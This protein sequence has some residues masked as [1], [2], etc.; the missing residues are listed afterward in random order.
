[1]CP[2]TL[3]LS[4]YYDGELSDVSRK[5]I[6]KHLEGCPTC[7]ATLEIFAAQ[8]RYLQSETLTPPSDH[9]RLDRFWHY[10]GKFRF[11]RYHGVP[12]RIGVPLPL[13]VAVIL[14]L[15]VATGFN[16]VIREGDSRPGII[17]LAPRSTAP[18]LV[19]FS[20]TPSDLE[21]F[22]SILEG[23]TSGNDITYTLPEGI[24]VSHFGDPMIIRSTAP[25]RS[26]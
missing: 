6:G 18:T 21:S 11:G 1:M 8:H 13:A 24:P 23:E 17:V 10:V 22:L 14:A 19:T 5:S 9:E 16:F 12:R 26:P 7:R 2:E 20:I 25:E 4:A 15:I 3:S